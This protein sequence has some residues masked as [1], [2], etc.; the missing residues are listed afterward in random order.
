MSPACQLLA[1]WTHYA[2]ITLDSSVA[3]GRH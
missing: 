1:E 2:E 3:P